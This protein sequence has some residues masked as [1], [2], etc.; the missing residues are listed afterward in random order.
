MKLSA[1]KCVSCGDITVG[2]LKYALEQI[3]TLRYCDVECN[4]QKV[5][6]VHVFAEIANNLVGEVNLN[7]NNLEMIP[8]KLHD[9]TEEQLYRAPWPKGQSFAEVDRLS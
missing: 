1:L 5:V 4:L 6:D 9:D 3:P 8:S 7:L 2:Q